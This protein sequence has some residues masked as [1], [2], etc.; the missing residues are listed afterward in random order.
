MGIQI[1]ISSKRELGT[2]LLNCPRFSCLRQVTCV[3][4]P[5]ALYTVKYSVQQCLSTT[6][7]ATDLI[8]IA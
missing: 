8:H 3:T 6:F 5:S 7:F 2:K 1:N 4:L